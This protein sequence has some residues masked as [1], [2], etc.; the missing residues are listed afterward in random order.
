MAVAGPASN[1]DFDH[2]V[3]EKGK[4]DRGRKTEED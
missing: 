4:E 3:T 1:V 2:R